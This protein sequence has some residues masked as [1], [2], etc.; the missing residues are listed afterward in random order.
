M[1]LISILIFSIALF[2]FEESCQKCHQR[3]IALEAT[4]KR[5]TLAYSSERAI[6]EAVFDY[7][8]KPKAKNSVMPKG[9]LNRWGVKEPSELNESRLREMVDIYYKK[10]N[11]K[12]RLH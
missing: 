6:K 5:Y 9:F 11:L 7:L 3:T 2:A 12:D 4:M 10:Y 1:K 8:K